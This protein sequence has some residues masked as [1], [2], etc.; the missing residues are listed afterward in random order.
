MALRSHRLHCPA[1]AYT[2]AA[3]YDT[4]PVPSSWRHLDLRAGLRRLQCP[5]HGVRTEAVPFARAGSDFTRDFEDL[6]GWL[7]T[8]MDK[9]AIVRLVRIDWDSVGRI[10]AR[11]MDYK[12]DP[13]RL[14]NLFV[15]GV[16]AV[17][18]HKGQQYITLVSDHQRRKLV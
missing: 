12:L 15:V 8:A 6:V 11:V 10:I 17:A 18:W 14:E 16:D 2:T 9:T 4:R 3:R 5:T 7:A 13:K 1:C